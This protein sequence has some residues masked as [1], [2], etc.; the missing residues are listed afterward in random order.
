LIDCLSEGPKII[1]GC[2][3]PI[4][5]DANRRLV[6]SF[7][8]RCDRHIRVMP[9]FYCRDYF[10]S[11]L[12]YF[13]DRDFADQADLSFDNGVARTSLHIVGALSVT[14][15]YEKTPGVVD[16]PLALFLLVT[17]LAGLAEELICESIALHLLPSVFGSGAFFWSEWAHKDAATRPGIANKKTRNSGRAAVNVRGAT[18]GYRRAS[19]FSKLNISVL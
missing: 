13:C 8:S 19:I 11:E 10:G 5:R 15:A 7:Q 4:Q 18:A 2:I 9:I 1:F 12:F 16:W 6:I 14:R 17:G 3:G